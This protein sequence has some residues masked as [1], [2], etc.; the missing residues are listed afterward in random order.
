M[1]TASAKGS[2]RSPP[3][4]SVLTPNSQAP[5]TPYP[6]I[7]R[8]IYQYIQIYTNIY[9]YIQIYTNIYKY[10]L[11]YTSIYQY[12]PIYT[13]KYKY[14]PIYANIYQYMPI[15]DIGNG[16]SQGLRME[17]PHQSLITKHLRPLSSE[18]S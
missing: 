11:I 3:T 5:K 7:S 4:K 6:D 17:T 12:I 1:K 10:I 15:Y 9:R 2:E 8:Y 13:N 14:I 16:L 18:R